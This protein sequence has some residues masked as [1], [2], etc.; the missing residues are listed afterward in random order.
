MG[1]LS[2]GL[3]GESPATRSE[4]VSDHR[5]GRQL[6]SVIGLQTRPCRLI[7]ARSQSRNLWVQLEATKARRGIAPGIVL[8][9]SP[10][11]GPARCPSLGD[12]DF[13]FI[14]HSDRRGPR[15]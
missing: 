5:H 3:T 9:D 10:R 13:Y 7:D 11:H 14:R 4:T 8:S 2:D 12:R 15:E 6:D 1:P